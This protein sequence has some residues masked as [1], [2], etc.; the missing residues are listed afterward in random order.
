ML[1][2]EVVPTKKEMN[3][4]QTIVTMLVAFTL[5]VAAGNA[6]TQGSGRG[7]PQT[8]LGTGFTYQGQ[9]KNANGPVNDTCDFQFSLWDA[10][11]SGTGR[12]FIAMIIEP[13]A[14]QRSPD[15]PLREM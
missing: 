2:L 7:V 12:L 6:T 15:R 14:Q 8:P 11:G 9:L 5:A 3:M 13:L 1:N 4:S 10:A